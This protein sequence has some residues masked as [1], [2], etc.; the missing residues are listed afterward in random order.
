MFTQWHIWKKMEIVSSILFQNYIMS[1]LIPNSSL[2]ME[3][4]LYFWTFVRFCIF[5]FNFELDSPFTF[6]K[7]K[8]HCT[9]ENEQLNFPIGLPY[10]NIALLLTHFSFI[11]THILS[12]NLCNVINF[13]FKNI[14][15]LYNL[16]DN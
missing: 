11:S 12:I 8:F 4:L 6:F 3:T 2:H 14:I 7:T 5:P 16:F 9:L 10:T 1:E 13:P 15:E